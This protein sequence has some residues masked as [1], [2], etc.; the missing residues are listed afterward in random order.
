[1][2]Y[3]DEFQQI[4]SAN[5]QTHEIGPQVCRSSV[6]VT[7]DEADNI[8]IRVVKAFK[9]HKVSAVRQEQQ[10]QQEQLYAN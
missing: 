9:A 4:T 3:Y 6:H 10:E 5:S 1:M 7:T 8:I 2:L